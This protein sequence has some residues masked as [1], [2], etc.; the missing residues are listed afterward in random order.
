MSC[1][2]TR[3]SNNSTGS[4][5]HLRSIDLFRSIIIWLEQKIKSCDDLSPPCHWRLTWIILKLVLGC[6]WWLVG[7]DSPSPVADWN[8]AGIHNSF[9]LSGRPA[10]LLSLTD[11]AS[12]ILV[13]SSCRHPPT[14]Q[15]STF[16]SG[17]DQDQS[18]YYH[19]QLQRKA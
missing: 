9:P 18:H 4:N 17:R 1:Q 11:P 5:N 15:P 3:S 10:R 14:I 13:D 8:P 7:G 19:F 6:I 12:P 2:E 16:Q